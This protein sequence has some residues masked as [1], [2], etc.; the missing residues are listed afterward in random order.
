MVSCATC[1]KVALRNSCIPL[2]VAREIPYPNI[3]ASG[4]VVEASS[5][6]VVSVSGVRVLGSESMR[7]LKRKGTWM[8]TALPPSIR[9]RL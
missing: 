1:A 9:A 5:V 4:R 2:A 8:V 6:V 3:M 7:C